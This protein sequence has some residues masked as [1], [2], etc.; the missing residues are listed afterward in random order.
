MHA[1]VGRKPRAL[2]MYRESM[3][4]SFLSTFSWQKYS[5]GKKVK[6]SISKK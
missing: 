3:L 2:I 1:L 6:P 4:Y 5:L